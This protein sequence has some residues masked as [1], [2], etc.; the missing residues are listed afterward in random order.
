MGI[1]EWLTPQISEHC[2]NTDPDRI[3]I[4]LIILIRPGL[5]SIFTPK[6]GTAQECNTSSDVIKPRIC[7]L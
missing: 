6:L 2:P 3:L 5:A 4:K 7:N 1:K